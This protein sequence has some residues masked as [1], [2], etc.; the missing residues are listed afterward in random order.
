[1]DDIGQHARQLSVGMSAYHLDAGYQ[2]LYPFGFGLSYGAFTYHGLTLNRHVIDAGEA[3][4][5]SVV[6]TN[7][8]AHG[9][10]E[11]VQLY[12]RDLAGSVTRPVRE[13][14]D[15]RRVHV[16]AGAST[17]VTFRLHADQLAFHGRDMRLRTEPGTFHLWIGGSSDAELQAE[18]RVQ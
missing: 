10:T 12:I 6:L 1:M 14:K 11:V 15:F 18:F 16:A 2:P 9:G 13:L 5:A 4:E 7:H 3:L 17:T 8:G